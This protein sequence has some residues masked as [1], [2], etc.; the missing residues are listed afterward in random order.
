MRKDISKIINQFI[1]FFCFE[2]VIFF[3]KVVSYMCD[4]LFNIHL[5][6]LVNHQKYIKIPS[7]PVNGECVPVNGKRHVVNWPKRKP[8]S[9][10]V[11]KLEKRVYWWRSK[12]ESK[13]RGISINKNFHRIEHILSF[14][15]LWLICILL[16]F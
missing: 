7:N 1:S 5:W 16:L 4:T 9:F 14:I 6:N 8:R 10:M 13:R 11:V 2:I 12:S 15:Y 3:T